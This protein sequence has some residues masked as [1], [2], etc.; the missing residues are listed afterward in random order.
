MRPQNFKNFKKNLTLIQKKCEKPKIFSERF[1]A[2][3]RLRKAFQ[4]AFGKAFRRLRRLNA[5]KNF[6][7]NTG[8]SHAKTGVLRNLP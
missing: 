7:Q 1:G 4:S 8:L 3:K 6:P 2:Q 5:R